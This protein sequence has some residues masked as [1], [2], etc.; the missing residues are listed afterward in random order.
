MNH[1]DYLIIYKNLLTEE[2]YLLLS[3]EEYVILQKRWDKIKNDKKIR[4]DKY[5]DDMIKYKNQNALNMFQ[6][7]ERIRRRKDRLE[8]IKNDYNINY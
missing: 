2:E 5:N 8:M 4:A 1:Y 7:K 6:N 3:E